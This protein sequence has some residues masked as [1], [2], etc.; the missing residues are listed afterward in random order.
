MIPTP[1][2]LMPFFV[3]ATAGLKTALRSIL[4]AALF[5]P[6]ICFLTSLVSCKRTNSVS[7][8]TAQAKPE[9]FQ[10]VMFAVTPVHCF[11]SCPGFFAS[12][13]LTPVVWSKFR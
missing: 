6:L 2:M 4:W 11:S 5:A 8:C 9:V 7:S 3:E 1:P 10:D 12:P 13:I